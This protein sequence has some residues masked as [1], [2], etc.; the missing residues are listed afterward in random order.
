MLKQNKKCS[1]KS[2][3]CLFKRKPCFTETQKSYNVNL[4]NK[5]QETKQKKKK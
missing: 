3:S 5:A 2:N 1:S 4:K